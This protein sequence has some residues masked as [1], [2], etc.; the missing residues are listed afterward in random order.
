ML[1]ARLFASRAQRHF[2]LLLIMAAIIVAASFI[3]TRIVSACP[4][5]PPQPLRTLYMKSNRI[6]VARAGESA[7]VQVNVENDYSTTLVCTILHV[8]ST[9]KGEGEEPIVYVYHW[10]WGDDED[11]SGVFKEGDNLLL[12][13]DR[14]P[15]GHGYQVDDE[16][17]GVKKLSDKAL[18]VYLQ[19]MDELASLL[20]QEKPDTAQIVEWLVRCAEDEATRWE[21]V[22]E[23]S[24]SNDVLRRM[25]ER[26]AEAAL[27][28]GVDAD[29]VSAAETP[30]DEARKQLLARFTF[31][32]QAEPDFARLLTDE[33]KTRL[34]TVLVG[35]QEITYTEYILLNMVKDW[36]DVRLVPFLLAQ[37]RKDTGET[38]YFK[39]HMVNI[40]AEV[41]DNEAVDELAA[42][43][44]NYEDENGET[45]GE[46]EADE[47]GSEEEAEG[48]SVQQ[49]RADA[50]A[51]KQQELL[52]SFIALAGGSPVN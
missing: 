29:D 50:A 5:A 41:L 34:G 52:E 14:R 47:S 17:Y 16:R 15:D 8:S 49:A 45:D 21:G 31:G 48:S 4:E 30:E 37:L 22:L 44:C 43:Y 39:K 25:E 3:T 46:E 9:I 1:T 23:L 7:I 20:R 51:R 26:K 18:K 10:K 24:R 27:K 12:F 33:Q 42:K 35:A 19:R 40:V 32:Y 38:P 2:A 6:V 28:T 13:L 11:I 36:N